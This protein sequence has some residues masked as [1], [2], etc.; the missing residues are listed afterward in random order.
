M[1]CLVSPCEK[2]GHELNVALRGAR[3]QSGGGPDALHVPDDAGNL[4]VVPQPGKLRHQ[5]N[6]RPGGGG[7]GARARPSRTQ[8]HA[9]GGEFVFRLHD[10]ESGFAIGRR[11]GMP[12]CNR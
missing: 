1:G 7:H 6:A 3:R 2:L 8:H 4:D 9:D 10:G 12:S 11:R 5:R